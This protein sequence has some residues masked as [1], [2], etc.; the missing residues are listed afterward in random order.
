MAASARGRANVVQFLLEKGANPKAV[1]KEGKTAL[2]L[3]AGTN[4]Q[5]VQALIDA[6]SDVNTT[7]NKGTTPIAAARRVL[8]RPG[9]GCLTNSPNVCMIEVPRRQR[10]V[11]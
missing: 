2:A 6:G 11:L 5:T 7:D 8:T 10:F 4:P 9:A 1:D 3:A